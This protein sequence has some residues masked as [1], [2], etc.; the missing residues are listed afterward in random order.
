MRKHLQSNRESGKIQNMNLNK[1]QSAHFF[2]RSGSRAMRVEVHPNGFSFPSL[3]Q[4][5]IIGILSLGIGYIAL[6]VVLR[7]DYVG[8]RTAEAHLEKIN[9]K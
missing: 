2:C 7:W 4:K 5:I 3:A 6:Q 1:P 8:V 9:K